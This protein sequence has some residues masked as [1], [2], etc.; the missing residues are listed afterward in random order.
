MGRREEA[1]NGYGLLMCQLESGILASTVFG[2]PTGSSQCLYSAAVPTGERHSS[3]YCICM[4]M[5][6]LK[7]T[8]LIVRRGADCRP[9]CYPV[10]YLWNQ[11][12]A[13]NIYSL[14]MHGLYTGM[15]ASTVFAWSISGSQCLQGANTCIGTCLLRPT[16]DTTVHILRA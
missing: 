14:P 5:V 12:E 1:H 2:E 7:L 16:N 13:H 15:L 3:T 8:M 11:L 10:L 4:G 6:D 9:L